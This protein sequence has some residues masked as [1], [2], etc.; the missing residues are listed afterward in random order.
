MISRQINLG[1]F[2]GKC[3]L[4]FNQILSPKLHSVE[5]AGLLDF[6]NRL[7]LQKAGT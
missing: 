1:Y 2:G 7:S 6:I 4:G 3:D 5:A